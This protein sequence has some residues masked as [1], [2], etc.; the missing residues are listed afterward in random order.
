MRFILL[1]LILSS[2]SFSG[3]VARLNGKP[4][5]KEEF[6]RFFTAYWRELFHFNSGEPTKEDKKI[7]LFEYIKGIILEEEAKRMGIKVS[8]EEVR[9][10]L[11]SFGIQNQSEVL[12]D[13]IRREI[14]VERLEERITSNL[15]VSE[16]EIEAY[17]L[18]N[19]REFYYPDQV[20]LLRVVVQTKE[21]A[22]KVKRALEDGKPPPSEEDVIV[23]D[24][25]WYSIQAL[26]KEIKKELLPYRVGRVS[27]P[28]RVEDSY[29]I[30]KITDKKE[31][32]SL[33][34][35]EA[36]EMVRSK[37]LRMKKVEAFRRWFKEVLKDYRLE[38]YLEEL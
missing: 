7:F 31:G 8:E 34:L 25:R 12:M 3:V 32:G 28:I 14:L 15:S 9:E 33:T 19:K 27:D 1:L 21:S 23:G 35:S 4:I 10:R 18:L 30:L 38:V 5:T 22:V 26:P 37:I 20:K 2:L 24:E 11:R 13:L 29:L 17:Y 36:R 16:G 6:E